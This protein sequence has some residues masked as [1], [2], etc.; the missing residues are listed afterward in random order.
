MNAE[1]INKDDNKTVIDTMLESK[2]NISGV[3]SGSFD[4]RA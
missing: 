4:A 3:Y 1:F 2:G